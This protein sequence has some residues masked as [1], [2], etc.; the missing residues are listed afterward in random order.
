[1]RMCNWDG[2][3]MQRMYR[4]LFFVWDGEKNTFLKE[5]VVEQLIGK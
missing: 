5:H 1:M 3:D 2:R 4:K